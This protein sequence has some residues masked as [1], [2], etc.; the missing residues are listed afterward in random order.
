[1]LTWADV[2]KLCVPFV[3]SLI[4]LWA[5]ELYVDRRERLRKQQFLWRAIKHNASSLPQALTAFSRIPEAFREKKFHV[6]EFITPAVLREASLRLAE[7]DHEHAHIY[8]D[9]ADASELVQKGLDSLGSLLRSVVTARAADREHLLHGIEAHALNV[10]KD[11]ITQAR[12]ELAVMKSLRQTSP[13]LFDQPTV[14]TCEKILNEAK[15]L[16][17]PPQIQH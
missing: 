15:A 2:L 8:S 3:F 17:Y 4:L 6:Q 14:D 12:S 7:L 5:K 13:G 16:V 9:Y 11:L 1:M 10:R